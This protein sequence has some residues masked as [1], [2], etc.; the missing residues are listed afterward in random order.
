M[1]P[2]KRLRA[3]ELD[4][5]AHETPKDIITN[6]FSELNTRDRRIQ[7]FQAFEFPEKQVILKDYWEKTLVKFFDVNFDGCVVTWR[8]IREQ[9]NIGNSYPLGLA[10][11]ILKLWD[12]KKITLLKDNSEMEL[13][14]PLVSDYVVPRK[15][16]GT[17]ES[18]ARFFKKPI[19]CL[20]P[21]TIIIHN[22]TF[23]AVYSS[24]L[25]R[26]HN[27]F[28]E[29]PMLLE[30]AFN[31]NFDEEFRDIKESEKNCFIF[32]L[33]ALRVLYK[34]NKLSQR[35]IC[36]RAEEVG[37]AEIDRLTNAKLLEKKI[38]G[39]EIQEQQVQR[40]ANELRGKALQLKKEGRDT[41]SK[42]VL[43]D[44][45]VK[46]K[47]L[48]K[49]NSVRLFLSNNLNRIQTSK[50]DSEAA[51][52]IEKTTDILR[53]AEGNMD[54]MFDNIQALEEVD[55]RN[56]QLNDLVR[57]AAGAD[58]VEKDFEQLD[59]LQ[60]EEELLRV[61]SEAKKNYDKASTGQPG[62][63]GG[64]DK[65]KKDEEVEEKGAIFRKKT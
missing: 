51:A 13:V 62:P 7:Y 35:F 49:L 45:L 4:R 28:P 60:N 41:E 15:Q 33:F 61:L 65:D 18:I 20:T 50:E 14:L 46:K 23:K 19:A 52:I 32:V 21:D 42:R 54:K 40:A 37:E 63:H 47:R 6:Y 29:S 38:A 43:N 5:E 10:S 56:T 48:D 3:D 57:Q 59:E 17:F 36:Y 26:L 44:Y 1:Q 39:I 34:I 58:D 31:A 22:S 16:V 25:E 2:R 53:K 11:I 8:K 9:F 24:V 12:E 30:D 55:L 64:Q 27:V